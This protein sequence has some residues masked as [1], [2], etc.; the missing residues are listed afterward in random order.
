MTQ[1]PARRP[2]ILAAS[3]VPLI[4]RGPAALL[5]ETPPGVS[6]D[7]AALGRTTLVLDTR[8]APPSMAL[9]RSL[10]WQLAGVIP[11]YARSSAGSVAD[12]AFYYKLLS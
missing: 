11:A 1:T 4:L 6:K 3:P 5:Q 10:G 12:S 7:R 9:Y 8:R 2:L